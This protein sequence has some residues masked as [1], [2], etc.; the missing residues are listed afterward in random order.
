MLLASLVLF[1]VQGSVLLHTRWVEDEN[2][3]GAVA[4]SF[5][6]T[7]EIRQPT[8]SDE[9]IE[10]KAD[11]RPPAMAL[12][13]AAAYRFLGVGPV[14]ARIPSLLMSAGTVAVTFFIASQLGG[15]LAGGLA[16]LLVASDNFL[17]L[18]ARTVRPEAGVTFWGA[19][20]VALFLA[21]G[22]RG[23]SLWL[24][25]F[26]GVA[27]GVCW[28]YHMNAIGV[29][30]G[31]GVLVLYDGGFGFFRQRRFWAFS[32]GVV[33]AVSP[34]FWWIY[35]SEV[36]REAFAK[37]NSRGK[38]T[39][40]QYLAL[41]EKARYADFLGIGSVRFGLG[42]PV[43]LRLHIVLGLAAAAVAVARWREDI[44]WRLP[45]FCLPSLLLWTTEVNPTSRF[46]AILAPVLATLLAVAGVEAWK[47]LEGRGRWLAAAALAAI[48]VSQLAGNAIFL[49]RARQ[50]D[51]RA[52]T[53][54]LRNLIPQ[55]EPVYGALTFWMALHDSRD[56]KAFNRTPFTYVTERGRANYLILKDRVML[57]G[58]G[59]GYNDHEELVRE[60]ARYV[61]EHA[62]LVGKVPDPFYGDLEVYRVNR[63]AA[64]AG[65]TQGAEQ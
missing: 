41:F 65:R 48:F 51:Y 57:G 54:G 26:S 63:P 22:R 7:G 3:Y 47:R 44:G 32:L 20:A 9:D 19:L 61:A 33:L 52:V 14:E 13:V 55:G 50:A 25:L 64:P 56:Y 40:T 4:Y 18:A 38:T 62:T 15:P 37:L 60:S 17:F 29:I 10:S 34:F 28:D 5:H 59:Y 49:M 24:G 16:A 39:G 12:T 1:L 27:A 36:N 11:P 8:F 31:I 23:D 46:F 35:S 53:A 45:L 2:W 21:A 58:T 30:L 42:I 43:P 6:T